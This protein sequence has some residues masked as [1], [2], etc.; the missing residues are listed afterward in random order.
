MRSKVTKAFTLVEMLVVIACIGILVV[1]I[2]PAS[3]KTKSSSLKFACLN[4]CKQMGF[5]QQMFAADHAAGKSVYLGP[6]GSLTGTFLSTS[7]NGNGTTSQQADDDLNWL[8]GIQGNSNA[9]VTTLQT[10]VCPATINNVR[11]NVTTTT[12]YNNTVFKTLLDLTSKA[13]DK[14]HTTGHSYEV[15]GFWRTYN[16]PYFP[17]KTLTSVQHHTNS[18]T[19][20]LK[21]RGTISGP[22][23]IFTIVDELEVHTP[24][25]ENAPNP[26]AAHGLEGANVVCADAHCEFI[27]T[28]NWYDR[29]SMSEDDSSSQGKPYP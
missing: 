23:D 8:H 17:R 2:L 4:N 6:L 9:Y 26:Y 19:A 10:F 21:I 18:S 22:S 1:L 16:L 11:G 28:K 14:Y 7:T 3:A 24:Y 12:V 15:F 25:R 20:N 29:Y 5:G 27:A 13:V